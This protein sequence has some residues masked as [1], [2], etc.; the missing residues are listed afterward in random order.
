[1]KPFYCFIIC[2]FYSIA[3]NAQEVNLS[4]SVIFFNNKPVAYYVKELNESTPRYN[5]FII[6]L[7]KKLLLAATVVK[8]DAPIKDLKPFYYYDLILESTKDTFSIYYSGQAFTVELAELIKKYNLLSGNEISKT[9][10]RNFKKYYNGNIALWSKIRDYI[11]YLVEKRF[12]NEQAL[13]DRTKPV[14]IVNDK[15]IMQDGKKIGLIVPITP[16]S[17][18]S[19]APLTSYD[20]VT[21]PDGGTAVVINTTER[22]V[23]NTFPANPS[24]NFNVQLPSERIVDASCEIIEPVTNKKNHSNSPKSLYDIS[25]PYNKSAANENALWIICQYIEA[26]LL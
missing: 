10:W 24:E 26:Y 12:L 8:F 2:L 15:I 23:A 6:S 16:E 4:D 5:I 7:D 9:A 21:M 17:K 19:G 13:R 20:K 25:L 22:S 14:T 11:G 1:M 18:G 3:V